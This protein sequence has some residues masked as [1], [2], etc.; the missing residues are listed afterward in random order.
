M[1]YIFE[2]ARTLQSADYL[3]VRGYINEDFMLSIIVCVIRALDYIL[4]DDVPLVGIMDYFKENTKYGDPYHEFLMF[5]RW[6]DKETREILRLEKEMIECP[7]SSL[8]EEEEFSR[9]IG[10][11]DSEIE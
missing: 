11:H 2:H 1:G 3:R 8:S 5:L 6:S 9:S 7:F 10:Q 4:R